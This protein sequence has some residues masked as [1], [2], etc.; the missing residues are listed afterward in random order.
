MMNNQQKLPRIFFFPGLGADKRAFSNLKIKTSLQQ[1]PIDWLKPEKR[2]SLT[3][4]CRQLTEK[5]RINDGD[6]LVGL[7]FGGLVVTE[8]NKFIRPALSILISSA[9]TRKELPLIY[10]IAGGLN[11]HQ[12]IPKSAL[13]K[14]NRLKYYLF[15]LN[16]PEQRNLFNEIITD[17]DPDFVRWAVDKIVHWQNRKRPENLF[18]ING[19]A[20]RIM[21]IHKASTDF[22]IKDGSHFLTWENAEDVA[23]IIRRLM[24]EKG[25]NTGE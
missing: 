18:K 17:A 19:T 12:L 11:L 15:S 20:D 22:V 2:E 21:P 25:L 7:S 13:N 10:R 16:K 24:K 23:A 5:Y 3:A 9:S 8:I 4:Y 14:P 6:V 1:I